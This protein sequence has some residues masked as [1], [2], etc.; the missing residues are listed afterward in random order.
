MGV[1]HGLRDRAALSPD[2]DHVDVVLHEAVGPDPHAEL[3]G[4]TVEPGEIGSTVVVGAKHAPA[5]IAAVCDVKGPIFQHDPCESRHSGRV[6]PRGRPRTEGNLARSAAGIKLRCPVLL[7][8]PQLALLRPR[9]PA[10]VH[11]P[12]AVQTG[13]T[14]ASCAKEVAD[15]GVHDGRIGHRARDFHPQQLAKPK[16]HTMDR[17]LDGRLG[18][19][20][21]FCKVRI[22]SI[23]LALGQRRREKFEQ[24]PAARGRELVLQRCVRP[25]ENDPDPA[26]L[27]RPLGCLAV[28]QLGLESSLRV[29]DLAGQ[30]FPPPPRLA[31]RSA[32]TR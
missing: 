8:G 2:R 3:L 30:G 13:G 14:S 12:L 5:V 31:A 11:V 16:A 32:F 22:G 27:E 18:H 7:R 1:S 24:P 23:R 15:L 20:E 6:A 28:D 10:L 9:N 21:L 26:A 17:F 25:P 29:V 19:L 4:E